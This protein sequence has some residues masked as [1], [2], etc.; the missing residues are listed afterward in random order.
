[1]KRFTNAA[2]HYLQPMQVGVRVR[3]GAEALLH[4]FNRFIRDPD[5]CDT[6]TVVALIDFSNAFNRVNR[7]LD[8]FKLN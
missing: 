3:N 8:A 6:D 7:N 2:A 4:A 1:V 5:K